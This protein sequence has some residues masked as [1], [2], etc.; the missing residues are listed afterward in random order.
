[1]RRIILEVEES[2]GEVHAILHVEPSEN[3]TKAEYVLAE[4]LI[5]SLKVNI[6]SLGPDGLGHGKT[7]EQANAAANIDRDIR[8]AG[9]DKKC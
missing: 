1:M 6:E 3:A 5:A 7:R 9:E 4:L 2:G 8:Q